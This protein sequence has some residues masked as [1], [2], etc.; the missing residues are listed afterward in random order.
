MSDRLYKCY[1]ALAAINAGGSVW[2][3]SDGRPVV[4]A[5]STAVAVAVSF[6]AFR[7]LANSLT[8]RFNSAAATIKQTIQDEADDLHCEVERVP[9]TIELRA[10]RPG[11]GFDYPETYRRAREQAPH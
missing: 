10:S 1:G 5:I 3:C 4:A 6:G 2:A 7:Q 11:T 8:D 9:Q